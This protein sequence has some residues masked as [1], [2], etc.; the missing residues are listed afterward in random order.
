MLST[1]KSGAYIPDGDSH[2]L[3]GHRYRCGGFTA[4]NVA[5][6]QDSRM[7]ASIGL[8]AYSWVKAPMTPFSHEASDKGPKVGRSAPL[9]FLS[10]F[11]WPG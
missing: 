2:L 8:S 5:L 10:W 6:K 11:P 4:R 1:L 7:G 9:Q 3:L